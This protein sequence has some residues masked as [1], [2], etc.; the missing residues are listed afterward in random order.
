LK[1]GTEQNDQTILG[2]VPLGASIY[3]TDS[4]GLLNPPVIVDDERR[5][6]DSLFRDS[7]GTKKL[8]RRF[9]GRQANVGEAENYW[10]QHRFERNLPGLCAS[11]PEGCSICAKEHGGSIGLCGS[12]RDPER[13]AGVSREDHDGIKSPAADQLP[14]PWIQKPEK[15]P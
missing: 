8:D 2:Q 11:G 4:C 9:G 14:E 5:E 6:N 12:N 1:F 3:A 13:C 10:Q 15:T 7:E